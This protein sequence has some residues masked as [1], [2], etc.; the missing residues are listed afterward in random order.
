MDKIEL[1]KEQLTKQ[2][3]QLYGENIEK[4]NKCKTWNDC[5]TIYGNYLVFW[6][7]ISNNSTKI[8]KFP[9]AL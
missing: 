9:I 6:F 8:L 5:F 1:I 2:A 3:K 4:P 7:N